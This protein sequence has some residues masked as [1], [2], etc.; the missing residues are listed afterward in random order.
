MN[1]ATN[2][3]HGPLAPKLVTPKLTTIERALALIQPGNRVYQPVD[4][5]G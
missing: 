2:S 5:I 4:E 1:N 3:M